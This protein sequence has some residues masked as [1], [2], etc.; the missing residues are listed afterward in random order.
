MISNTALA[1]MF[2][3]PVNRIN[4]F[5]ELQRGVVVLIDTSKDFLQ[6]DS[7]IPVQLLL[8][9]APNSDESKAIAL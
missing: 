5:D 1:N 7:V 3:S 2:N 8:P 6:A 9:F 4:L